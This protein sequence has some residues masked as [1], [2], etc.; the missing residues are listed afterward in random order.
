M[1][2]ILNN[3][4]DLR[5]E[6]LGQLSPGFLIGVKFLSLT[7]R[8]MEQIRLCS[9]TNLSDVNDGQGV[10]GSRFQT[11]RKNILRHSDNL[12]RLQTTSAA[13][14]QKVARSGIQC[15]HIVDDVGAASDVHVHGDGG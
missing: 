8:P 7:I 4:L 11:R 13:I 9:T 10:G 15:K 2:S 3:L 12:E 14:S 5:D 6:V 1:P